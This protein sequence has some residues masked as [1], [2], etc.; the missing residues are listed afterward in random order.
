MSRSEVEEG[1]RSADDLCPSLA[2]LLGGGAAVALVS[3]M[4]LPWPIAIASIVLG[5]LMIAGADVDARSYLLPDIVT[6]GAA[7]CGIAAAPLLDAF[8]PW[9]AVAVA[10]VR[11]CGVAAV[12]ELLRRCYARVRKLEGLGF[13]DVKLAAAVGAWLP[14]DAVPLCFGLAASAAL[15][16]ATVAH[17]RGEPIEGTMKLPFGAF[18]CP[19]LWLVF[20]ASVL[21]W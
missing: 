11:T 9:L 12:L 3:G 17:L 8:D 15:V 5:T 14:L 20:Y 13:G 18:L 19:A 2:I 4:F 7:G 16:A 6:L 10:L 1:T 21:P